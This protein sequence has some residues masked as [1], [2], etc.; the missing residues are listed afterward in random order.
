VQDPGSL[1]RVNLDKLYLTGGI[2]KQGYQDLSRRRSEIIN[3]PA[4]EEHARSKAEAVNA[5]L[6]AA[7]LKTKTNAHNRAWQV[8]ENIVKTKQN[9][10][11]D[12]YQTAARLAITDVSGSGWG[13]TP[14]YKM[15]VSD[16]PVM[17]RRKV[18]DAFFQRF[19]RKPT[20]GEVVFYYGMGR[21]KGQ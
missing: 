11:Y 19:K 1:K 9:P 7:G 20:D 15:G 21:M 16:V 17:E 10:T 3:N 2:S 4:K 18:E 6:G 5:I 12:D 13:S 8:V 14:F